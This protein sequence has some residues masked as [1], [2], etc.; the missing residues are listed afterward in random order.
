MWFRECDR[1][2][3]AVREVFDLVRTG[4][5][6]LETGW[7]EVEVMYCFR[8]EHK[9]HDAKDSPVPPNGPAIPSLIR[10]AG[11]RAHGHM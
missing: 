10:D 4:R 1:V 2:T 7:R 9:N 6:R 11:Y 3:D 5:C 8:G